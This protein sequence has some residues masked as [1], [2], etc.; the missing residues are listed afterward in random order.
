[1]KSAS[2]P[3]VT[4]DPAIGVSRPREHGRQAVYVLTDYLPSSGGTSTAARA[5]AK[6]LV[7]RGWTM[8]VLTRRLSR[9]WPQSETIE[10]VRIHRVG[11]PG[12]S[13][14][15]KLADLLA[16]WWW[17][18]RMRRRLTWVQTF[19][20]PDYA[21][22]AA[23]AGLR[24]RTIVRW[25][26]RGDPDR[27]LRQKALG[28][29]RLLLLRPCKHVALSPAMAEELRACGIVVDATI[30]VP[31]DAARFRPATLAER[32]AARARLGILAHCTI[33]F[34][35]HLEPR[36]GIDKLL[37]AF[38]TIVAEGASVHLLV[39]GGTHGH[40]PDLGPALHDFV[41]VH[42]LA[43]VVTFAG[44]VSDVAPY[45]HA[46]DIFCL[47]S[48]R[49][50]MSNSLVEAMACGLACVVPAAAGGDELLSDGAGIIPTSTSPDDLASSLRPLVE[51]GE[52][53]RRLGNAAT[54]RVQAHRLSAVVDQYEVL[55]NSLPRVRTGVG[56]GPST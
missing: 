36:K 4:Q 15:A 33:V 30:P 54:A 5:A 1:M 37:L 48:S 31:A 14:V 42:S 13:K 26:T 45:L 23:V 46:S 2:G 27:F 16:S 17:L 43:D 49:E 22:A 34:T 12:Y 51:D 19:M 11:L 35:G 52:L 32:S 7:E 28:W 38:A 55:Y 25:A 50:G 10:G 44:V 29:I 39:V 24:R 18:L 8:H 40:A 9:K 56:D 47:P 6:E 53:R 20:D 21:V 41:R 3:R